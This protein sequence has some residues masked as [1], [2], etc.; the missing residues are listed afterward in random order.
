MNNEVS[1]DRL[2]QSHG[3]RDVLALLGGT[4][5]AFAAA[6]ALAEECKVGPPEHHKGPAVF[7]DMDQLELDASYD[8]AY[9][10]PDIARAAQRLASSS[11]AVRAR[12]GPP[13][14]AS[15]GSSAVEGLDIYRTDRAKA[16]IFVF[17]HGGNWFLGSAKDSGY[18]AE[19]FVRAGAHYVALDFTSVKD[20]GGDLG[21]MAAQVRSGIAW[22]YQNAASFDGDPDR[23]YIGGHSSGGHLCG[24]ALV[25]DWQKDFGLPLNAVKGGLCMS[26]MFEM[27]PVRLSWRRTYVSFTD[28]MEDEMSAQRHVDRLRAP[29]V[30]TTGTFETPDFQRQ[31]RDFAAVVKAAGKEADLIVAPNFHH[32]EM[33]ESLG[34]PYGP[35]GR[36]A[37]AMMKLAPA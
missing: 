10:E 23:I 13:R 29:V 37:L 14:R 6:P 21:V 17:I 16:P 32:Q 11:E 8:Q 9:Y 25:T 28:S 12:L 33:A 34:N 7:M 1:T 36:A 2:L 3:R 31:S 5:A 22:V 35:N 4:A 19:M 30:V 24:V 20:V 15:Y 18:A 27:R 26:G